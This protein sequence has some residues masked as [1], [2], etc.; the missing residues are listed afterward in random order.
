[1]PSHI[2]IR[3]GYYKKGVEVN[4][5]AVKGY[6]SY[7]SKYPVVANGSF[8]Y[9]MHN[10][11]MKAACAAMDGQYEPAL[12]FAKE[13]QSSVDSAYLDAGGYF[14]MYSQYLYTT[15]LLTEIRFG[16]WDNILRMPIHP[17][18]RVYARSMQHFGRG[19]AYART[20]QLSEAL[21][22]LEQ[23]DDSVNSAQLQEHPSAFNPG[24]AAVEVAQKVLQG[25]IA[26]EKNQLSEAIAFLKEAVDK[27]DN[28]LYN[29]PKDWVL[30]VRQYLGYALLKARKYKD[31]EKVYKQDLAIN[32][33][34]V[35]SLTGLA[36]ALVKQGKTK[37]ATKVQ[38]QAKKVQTT[39][40]AK[41]KSSVF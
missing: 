37:E 23:M 27:E 34:N 8:I 14:G 15:P 19:M 40:N 20:Q 9:L 4:E 11:H 3:S 32:P 36:D 13:T 29:E 39:D 16:K 22:E 5:A 35:W 6:Q 26:E 1:M 10:L 21:N 30:P 28:M 41:I 2:Y 24:I 12:Q 38:Q 33:N 31:A 18:E 7:L 25:V 17:Q